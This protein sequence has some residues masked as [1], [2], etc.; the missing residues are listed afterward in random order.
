[1]KKLGVIGGLGP[2]A[3]AYFFELIIQMTD[4]KSDQEHIEIWIHNCPSIPDRTA[5]LFDHT[6]Q[7]PLIPILQS[8]K[9][10]IQQKVDW[11]AIPCITAHSF[12]Q[13]FTQN[14]SVPVI[15]MVE[16]TI[17]HL[18]EYEKK[19]IGIM[20]TD[21]TIASGLFQKELEKKG[22]R[23]ILPD[24]ECQGWVMELI[25]QD[26]KA[27]RQVEIDKFQKVTDRLR[28]KGAETIIL[29]CTELSLIKRDYPMKA[30]YLDA[31]EVLAKRCVELCEAPLKEEYRCLIT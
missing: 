7:N 2:M 30:G 10:L 6:R 4:A 28:K 9:A 24:K 8:A 31:M 22:M 1:M 19:T 18:K 23:W 29:G 21:G 16:E 26:I 17:R 25:Y 11:I 20:A 3:T 14:L 27:G 5:Y 12:Y 15:H 13:E